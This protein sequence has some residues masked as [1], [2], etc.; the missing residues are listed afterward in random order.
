MNL[1]LQKL[2]RTT[3]SMAILTLASGSAM[4]GLVVP[5][6]AASWVGGDN[7]LGLGST[8][9]HVNANSTKV[10]YTGNPSLTNDGWGHQGSWLNF[11]LT[12]ASDTVVTLSSAATNAPGFTIYRTDGE[13]DGG[14]GTATGGIYGSPH[15]FNQV[16]QAGTAGIIWATDNSVS[17]STAGNK[18]VNGLVE[19][20]GYVNS[21]GNDYVNSWGG[22]IKAGAFDTSISNLYEQGVSGSVGVGLATLNLNNLAA[23]WYT[24]YLGGSNNALAGS[25]IDV[26]IASTSPVGSVPVPGAVWLFGS[27]LIGLVGAS[28]KK[29]Q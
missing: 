13:F 14:S 29:T 4:A 22:A 17:P 9:Q 6:A 1:S 18:T 8:I 2:T 12:S 24:L 7:V 11:Q 3:L 19:T 15:K 27:A 5:K 20:L 23:G 28:Q 26:S 25:Q 21:S 16:A 10:G